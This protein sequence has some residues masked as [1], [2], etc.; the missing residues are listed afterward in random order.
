MKLL[1]LGYIVYSLGNCAIKLYIETGLK[2]PKICNPNHR[3][4]P[5]VTTKPYPL[6]RDSIRVAPL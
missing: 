1:W 2:G 4:V 3:P 6:A 5:A